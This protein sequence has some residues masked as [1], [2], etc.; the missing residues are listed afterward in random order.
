MPISSVKYDLEPSLNGNLVVTQNSVVEGS[1][2]GYVSNEDIPFGLFLVEN[3]SNSSLLELPS[4]A[5]QNIVGAVF[6]ADVF[7]VLSENP[8]V[9]GVPQGYPIAKVTQGVMDLQVETPVITGVTT[10]LF[11]RHTDEASPTAIQS[12]GRIRSDDAAGNASAIAFAYRVIRG[13]PA[14]GLIRLQFDIRSNLS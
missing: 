3:A 1:M 11:I 4:A 12:R 2:F 10:G 8:K 6:M 14:G 9:S 7:E 13:A 5:G